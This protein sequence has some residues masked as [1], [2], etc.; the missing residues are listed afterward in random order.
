MHRAKSSPF[1]GIYQKDRSQKD[2]DSHYESR[3]DQETERQGIRDWTGKMKTLRLI[4]PERHKSCPSIPSKVQSTE[5]ISPTSCLSKDISASNSEYEI[6]SPRSTAS[7]TSFSDVKS[8]TSDEKRRS[9]AFNEGDFA[10]TENEPTRQS[11]GLHRVHFAK[12]IDEFDDSVGK[13]GDPSSID[14]SLATAPN[15]SATCASEKADEGDKRETSGDGDNSSADEFLLEEFPYLTKHGAPKHLDEKPD[16]RFLAGPDFLL[17]NLK[18]V[19]RR[20]DLD[21]YHYPGIS[22]LL[23]PVHER[24]SDFSRDSNGVS[25]SKVSK[26][27]NSFNELQFEMDDMPA[28]EEERGSISPPP[29][30]GETSS[31]VDDSNDGVDDVDNLQF[32]MDEV[33]PVSGEGVQ[34]PL[35]E[36]NDA[37]L[38]LGQKIGENFTLPTRSSGGCS[39]RRSQD[40]LYRE[41]DESVEVTT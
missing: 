12:D 6:D 18:G 16:A 27:A 2:V 38:T 32:A 28:A 41:Q 39:P 19:D 5:A 22:G 1:I 33:T 30:D 29:V 34:N 8:Y 13:S 26:K 36:G 20:H 9:F 31:S 10:E 24:S 37:S 7:S 21:S 14:D 35:E 40:Y 15:E 11:K 4:V 17:F 25:D 23:A 3:V